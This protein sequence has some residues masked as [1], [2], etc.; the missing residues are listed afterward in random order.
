MAAIEFFGGFSAIASLSGSGI[1]FY[2]ANFGTSVPVGETQT[3]M[4][5]TNSTGTSQG[6]ELWS[7]SRSHPASGVVGNSG[8]GLPLRSIP[9]YQ[10]PIN[11]RF[12]HSSAV[13][14]QNAELRA[15]DRYNIDN[16]P[17]G[18]TCWAAQI[19]HPELAQNNTGS[20]STLWTAIYGSGSVLELTDSPGTSGLS[21]N[22]A[23]T[24]DTRHDYYLAVSASP[25]SVG[26]KLWSLYLS[27]EYL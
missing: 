9:N 4:F 1:G 8:S 16:N 25:D 6:P 19:I 3:R 27:L 10:A 15:Y 22:G 18:V 2:G 26:S 12:T 20:G 23:G 7:I 14:V 13:R 11:A 17:S 24:T 5:I 21:P